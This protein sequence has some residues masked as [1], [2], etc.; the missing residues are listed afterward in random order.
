MGEIE[1]WA[2][3]DFFDFYWHLLL[4]AMFLTVVLESKLSN[5]A[6]HSFS[7]S[8]ATLWNNLPN[9]LKNV[10]SVDQFWIGYLKLLQ[11]LRFE[12]PHGNHVKQL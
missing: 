9:S 1:F 11:I 4:N 3:R 8:G 6:A 5:L 12:F 10:G 7:Y 2:V